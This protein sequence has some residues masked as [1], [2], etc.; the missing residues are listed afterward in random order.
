MLIVTTSK[1]NV[2]EGPGLSFPIIGKVQKGEL[3][4][5]T[6]MENKWY[7]IE[8]PSG[9]K[10]WIA[11]WLVEERNP[12]EKKGRITVD[13]LRL[14]NG[15]S[16]TDGVLETLP[17]GI[18]VNILGQKREWLKVET[19][20]GSGW[21]HQDYV[22]IEKKS[23]PK[24]IKLQ[25]PPSKIGVII[26][27]QLNVREEPSLSSNIK[28]QL[29]IGDEVQILG[30]YNE[31][32]RI[33]TEQE[34]GWIHQ[35]FVKFE[36]NRKDSST[37][38]EEVVILYNGTK[39]REKATTKSSI[40]AFVQQGDR[41]T[42]LSKEGDW[43]KISLPYQQEGYIASWVVSYKTVQKKKQA[44][45]GGLKGKT[46]ILDPGHGGEDR[47]T[48]GVKGTFEKFLTL[49]TAEQLYQKLQKAGANVILT[50]DHDSNVSLPLRVAIA[51]IYDADAFISIHYD[52]IKDPTINGFT[53]YYYHND[54]RELAKQI[55]K[56]L[57]QS[58]SLSDRGVHFG[59]YHV[60]RQNPQPS[61]LLE[62]GFLS[63]KKEEQ[64]I[65]TNP[66]QEVTTNGIY[67]GLRSYFSK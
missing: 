21:I 46:I 49:R 52:S 45:K 14:R 10:G 17:K 23:S 26:G 36:N 60:L 43:F 30:L 8:H 33:K 13:G 34:S 59:N 32:V 44:R 65:I 64:K 67:N 51:K 62:L 19:P 39:I 28:N 53:T 47:G 57:K 42:V 66:Y 54:D 18:E 12:N 48:T 50:R 61:I 9:K 1:S 5:S 3:F 27:D 20:Y 11:G 2:R 25:K 37:P 29:K 41:Y 40:L 4:S 24:E 22:N 16:E 55:H 15:P 31:W 58:I 6:Q 63:N 35:S 38:Q 7:Q 56:G